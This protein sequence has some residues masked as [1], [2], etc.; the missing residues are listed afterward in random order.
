MS[1]SGLVEFELTPELASAMT[2]ERADGT[3]SHTYVVQNPSGRGIVCE[4]CA[5][6]VAFGIMRHQKEPSPSDT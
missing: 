4:Q 3:C 2:S 1:T 6:A 5:T